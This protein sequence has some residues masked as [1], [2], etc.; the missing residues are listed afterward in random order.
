MERGLCPAVSSPSIV[1]D[2]SSGYVSDISGKIGK[3]TL[4]KGA[5]A[6]FANRRAIS[7]LPQPVGP[8]IK[9]FLGTMSS[10]T[11]EIKMWHK[12]GC[13]ARCVDLCMFLSERREDLFVMPAAKPTLRGLATFCLRHLF[14][15]AFATAFL[16]SAWSNNHELI[17]HLSKRAVHS[18]IVVKSRMTEGQSERFDK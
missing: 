1:V 13:I 5:S 12:A 4:T 15:R 6:I 2:S 3:Q 17:P 18:K 16:A 7:V 11:P 10:C 8:I 14:R 9:M